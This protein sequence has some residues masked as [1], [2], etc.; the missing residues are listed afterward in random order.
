MQEFEMR[1][2]SRTGGAKRLV[3]LLLLVL[4]AML[5]TPSVA[6]SPYSAPPPGADQRSLGG[7]EMHTAPSTIELG[8]RGAATP[9]NSRVP[10]CDTSP[11]AC[12]RDRQ[13]TYSH[14]PGD[15]SLCACSWQDPATK[16]W[17]PKGFAK[18][19]CNR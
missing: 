2:V 15:K 14:A 1:R 9:L 11:D 4:A 7:V 10:F 19:C 17:E 5:V 13:T 12:R 3:A 16:R 8:A 6:Q 18:S